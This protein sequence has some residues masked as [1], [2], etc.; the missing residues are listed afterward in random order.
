MKVF[1]AGV[2]RTGTLS[3]KMALEQVGFG[4]C[5]HMTVVLEDRARH[6]P[7]WNDAVAGNPDWQAIYQ[8][9]QSAVDWPSATFFREL[10]QAFPEAKFILTHRDPATWAESFGETIYTALS[11]HDQAPKE[12]QPWLNMCLAVIGRAGFPL[13][14]DKA[15]LESRFIEH[16]EAVKASIPADKLLVTRVKDGWEPICRFLEIDQPEGDFP[17][18]ND[19]EEFWRLVDEGTRES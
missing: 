5:H 8:G 16:N 13:G 1:G 6:V 9:M 7:L 18:S 10:H 4:P 3:L 17:R 2:G 12:V 19:R 11:G 15:A 14:L